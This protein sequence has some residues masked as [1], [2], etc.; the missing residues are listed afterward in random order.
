MEWA[1]NGRSNAISALI[2]CLLAATFIRPHSFCLLHH[3]N[4]STQLIPICLFWNYT[5]GKQIFSPIWNS[6]FIGTAGPIQTFD[7]GLK[8]IMQI[9]Y[10]KNSKPLEANVEIM[11]W[12]DRRRIIKMIDTTAE[13]LNKFPVA[14]NSL[15]LT[16]CSLGQFLG[17]KLMISVYFIV[18]VIAPFVC[19]YL[20]AQ[21]ASWGIFTPCISRLFVFAVRFLKCLKLR[22]NEQSVGNSRTCCFTTEPISGSNSLSSSSASSSSSSSSLSSSSSFTSSTITRKQKKNYLAQISTHLCILFM[23][24]MYVLTL[25]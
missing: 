8:F 25:F 5:A 14:W 18:P 2:H 21:V 1:G 6:Y 9:E 20:F 3:L 15:L 16:T 13:M 10:P 23:F 11:N 19:L 17:P 12:N 4:R 22:A 7:I 24:Y